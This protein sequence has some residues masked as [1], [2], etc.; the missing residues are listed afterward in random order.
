MPLEKSKPAKDIYI[1][2]KGEILINDSLEGKITNLT[3]SEVVSYEGK[4]VSVNNRVVCTS[5]NG[6]IYIKSLNEEK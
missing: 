5:D 4:F 1:N 3:T 6:K 2:D